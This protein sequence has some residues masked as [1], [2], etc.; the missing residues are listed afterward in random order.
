MTI[1]HILD[2]LIFRPV[3][4]SRNNK[5]KFDTSFEEFFIFPEKYV[6]L[7]ILKMFGYIKKNHIIL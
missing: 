6:S 7:N 2:K 3:V 1:E 4:L 5:F